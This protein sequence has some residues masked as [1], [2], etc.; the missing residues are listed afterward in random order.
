MSRSNGEIAIEVVDELQRTLAALAEI[1]QI[2]ATA[3]ENIVSTW[4]ASKEVLQTED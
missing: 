3:V 2:A 1:A 4:E